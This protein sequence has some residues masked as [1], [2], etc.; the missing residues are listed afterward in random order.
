MG[1]AMNI[2]VL[3][4]ADMDALYNSAQ[5]LMQCESRTL[6]FSMIRMLHMAGH[7]MV[8]SDEVHAHFIHLPEQPVLIITRYP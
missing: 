2:G 5:T 1:L 6:F 8:L 4:L 7:V 3:T